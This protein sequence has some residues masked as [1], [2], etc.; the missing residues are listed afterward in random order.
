MWEIASKGNHVKAWH[1]VDRENRTRWIVDGSSGWRNPIYRP[2]DVRGMCEIGQSLTA[3]NLPHFLSDRE[4]SAE[5][6][7][8]FQYLARELTS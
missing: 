7:G 3:L 2:R 8:T 1:V 5:L 4:F 6:D